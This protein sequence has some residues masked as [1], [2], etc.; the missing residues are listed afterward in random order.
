MK[1]TI[2]M[3][4]FMNELCEMYGEDELRSEYNRELI[5]MADLTLCD[6]KIK[7]GRFQP[8]FEQ[9]EITPHDIWLWFRAIHG[10][11]C[12]STNAIFA[13]QTVAYGCSRMLQD[14]DH[15]VVI[16]NEDEILI[17]IK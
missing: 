4:D 5:Y 14:T 10:T 9:N 11:N 17:K 16:L 7:N 6:Y 2:K 15:L 12:N 1:N 8:M 13:P 3:N